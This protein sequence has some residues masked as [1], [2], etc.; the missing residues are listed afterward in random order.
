MVVFQN[1]AACLGIVIVTPKARVLQG[2][3]GMKFRP[4]L[5]LRLWIHVEREPRLFSEDE[6]QITLFCPGLTG[7][8]EK[9]WST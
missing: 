7:Y 9:A 8:S 3:A 5:L 1:K 4:A 2:N 6:E